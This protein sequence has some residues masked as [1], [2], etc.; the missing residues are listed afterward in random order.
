MFLLRYLLATIKAYIQPIDFQ[1][2]AEVVMRL[3]EPQRAAY[4]LPIEEESSRLD[5]IANPKDGTWR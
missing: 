2:G 4:L 1:S 5:V 3:R